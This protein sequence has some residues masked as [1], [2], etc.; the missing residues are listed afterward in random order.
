MGFHDLG[1]ERFCSRPIPEIYGGFRVCSFHRPGL[2]NGPQSQKILRAAGGF[3]G[4]NKQFPFN[5]KIGVRGYWTVK[6]KASCRI[7][8]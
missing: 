4:R 3:P 6:V 5:K 1:R 8:T 7:Y 2:D